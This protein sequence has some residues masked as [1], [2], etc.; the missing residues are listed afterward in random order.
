MYA[1]SLNEYY[2]TLLEENQQLHKRR[3]LS[4]FD[5]IIFRPRLIHTAE[6]AI[7]AHLLLTE[8]RALCKKQLAR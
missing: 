3:L 8:L 2:T 1:M 5:F 4:T 7:A 6:S